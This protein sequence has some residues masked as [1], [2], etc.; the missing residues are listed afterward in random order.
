[1]PK[2]WPIVF[3]TKFVSSE[4][5]KI[6]SAF[7][8]W[9]GRTELKFFLKN[10]VR[11]ILSLIYSG[12]NYCSAMSFTHPRVCIADPRK[13][14]KT[15]RTDPKTVPS[16]FFSSLSRYNDPTFYEIKNSDFTIPFKEDTKN[17]ENK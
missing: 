5:I 1:M 4:T 17:I 3:W 14:I 12:D 2:A 9:T 6:K 13:K 15:V 7:Y 16:Q 8:Y 11:L 10:G